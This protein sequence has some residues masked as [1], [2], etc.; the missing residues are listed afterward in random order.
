MYAG[1]QA[2]LHNGLRFTPPNG[3]KGFTPDMWMPGYKAPVQTG[4]DRAAA[5]R[6]RHAF[7]QTMTP[8]QRAFNQQQ[9]IDSQHRHERARKA[10]AEG[11]S[12][13][14]VIAIV[15]GRE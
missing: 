3:L 15:E 5:A 11:A 6:L 14:T 12:R 1:I 2:T 13:E 10:K 4:A 8:E 7:S 9:H